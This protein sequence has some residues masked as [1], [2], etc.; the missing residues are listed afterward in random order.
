M[1]ASF[2]FLSNITISKKIL[3]RLK[4]RFGVL[5]QGPPG[6]G[7][8][9]A[10]ANIISSLLARG[11]RVL[12]TSQ[13]ENALKVLRDLIP[14]EIRSLCVSQLGSDAESK[15]QLND[16]VVEIGKRLALRNSREPEE[17]IRH[18][19]S[20]LKTVREEQSGLHQQIRDWAELDSCKITIGGTPKSPRTRPPKNV[21]K[22]IKIIRGCRTGSPRNRASAFGRRVEGVCAL[23]GGISPQDRQACLQ[24]LPDP[25]RI[26]STGN[27]SKSL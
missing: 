26:Q 24:Y 16:S 19:G 13:T 8:S 11:K 3:D 21:R 7:K 15:K 17:R 12:V 25:A 18:I 1:T 22:A 4:E 5:V 6:T 14:P 20:E 10:I 2:S 27:I 9:H 23:L